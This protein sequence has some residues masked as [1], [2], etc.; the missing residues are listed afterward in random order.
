MASQ[1]KHLLRLTTCS[2]HGEMRR[3]FMAQ[4][5]YTQARLMGKGYHIGDCLNA[6]ITK[7]RNPK[8]N[9]LV[10]AFGRIVAENIDSFSCMNSH[11]VLKRL[12]LEANI[13]CEEISL[14]M[15][16]LGTVLHRTPLSLSFS[17]MDEGRFKEVFRLMCRYIAETYWPEMDEAEIAS[18]AEL[19]A[20]E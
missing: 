13:E 15:E 4:D 9:R 11:K 8:F 20:D 3:V 19:M 17:S 6:V 12:Q 5:G 18:M 7:A 2:C 10:H 16:G 1:E 14:Q